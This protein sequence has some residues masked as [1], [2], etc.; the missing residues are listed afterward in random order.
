MT[1]KY[2][3]FLLQNIFFSELIYYNVN[4]NLQ[5]MSNVTNLTINKGYEIPTFINET[6]DYTNVS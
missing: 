1:W 2:Y 4:P 3:Y 5:Y 6:I